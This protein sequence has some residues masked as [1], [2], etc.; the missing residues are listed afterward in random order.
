MVHVRVLEEYIHFS[1]MYTP[2]HIFPV[3][4]IK[5]LINE[6]VKPTTPY[7]LAIGM[8][9]SVFHL[10][11]LFYPFVVQSFTAHIRTKELNKYHKAKNGFSGVFV[12]IT[13]H[14]KGCLVYLLQKRKIVSSCNVVSGDSI[15][16]A[17]AY[18]SQKYP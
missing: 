1:F 9:T 17:L 4:P 14:Q 16:S 18:T 10:R 12:G 6:D 13:Q 11:V 5:D 2:D 8:K 15:S 3:L 7:K